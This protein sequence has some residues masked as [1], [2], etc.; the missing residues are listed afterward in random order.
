MSELQSLFVLL[1]VIYLVDCLVFVRR[2][3]LLFRRWGTRWQPARPVSV[4]TNTR[5]NLTF[6]NP[7]PGVPST[8]TS[9]LPAC[10]LTPSG[11]LNWMPYSLEDSRCPTPP[12]TWVPWE[13]LDRL[14]VDRRSLL[15]NGQPFLILSSSHEAL[16]LQETIQGLRRVPAPDREQAIQHWMQST[17]DRDQIAR[18][19]KRT[20]EQTRWLTF[21]ARGLALL[22]AVGC[23]LLIHFLGLPQVGWWLLGVI[24]LF[25]V[26]LAF[27]VHRT[28]RRLYPADAD[29]RFVRVFTTGLAPLSAVRCPDLVARESLQGFHPLAVA[30]ELCPEEGFQTLA[31]RAYRDAHFPLFPTEPSSEA[32]IVEALAWS[33]REWQVELTKFLNSSGIKP[34]A[35]LLPPEASDS[36]HRRYCPRCLQQFNESGLACV[37]CG[38]R[39]TVNLDFAASRDFAKA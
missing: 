33:R 38:G 2:G 16:Q 27:L 19:R 3:S 17:L 4:L 5:G 20:V 9:S 28:H 26:C 35:L 34:A 32:A 6:A 7:W 22:L 14:Q 23:P 29:D 25:S 37:E 30:R 10:T 36:G 8:F 13:K 31:A 18:R 15:V 39:P 21:L 24:Y 11:L 1:L 12:L